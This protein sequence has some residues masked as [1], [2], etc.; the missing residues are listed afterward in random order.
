MST[1]IVQVLL[2]L[3]QNKSIFDYQDSHGSVV[4]DIVK[5]PFRKKELVGVVWD[6][7]KSK[8]RGKFELKNVLQI[9]RNVRINQPIIKLIDFVAHYTMTKPGSLANLMLYDEKFFDRDDDFVSDVQEII[10][11][12]PE[13]NDEQK[14]ALEKIVDVSKNKKHKTIL[15]DGST[16]S[17]KTE[18]Y[19]HAIAKT[20]EEHK[21]GQILILLPEIMLTEQLIARVKERF[22]INPA[23]WHSRVSKKQKTQIWHNILH[24]REK[25]VIGARSAL[26]L[27]YKNLQ[28]IIVDEEHDSSYKQEEGIIYNA[29][30]M[31]VAYGHFRNIPTLLISATPSIET[32]HNVDI[33]KYE[34]V[35]LTSRYQDHSLPYMHV[36]NMKEQRLKSGEWLSKHLRSRIKRC[37]DEGKQVLLFLNRKGYAPISMCISC[38]SKLECQSCSSFLVYHKYKNKYVCHHCGYSMPYTKDCKKCDAEES[39]VNCGPGVER[40]VEEVTKLWPDKRVLAVSRESVEDTHGKEESVIDLIMQEKVDVIVGTQILSKGYHFPKLGLVG[41]VDADIGL[42]GADL[43]SA[44]RT[45]QLLTQVSGRAGREGRGDAIIQ[46]YSPDNPILQALIRGK[47]EQFYSMEIEQ[48]HMVSM[49]PFSRLIALVVSAVSEKKLE[50]FVNMMIRKAPVSHNIKVLGPVEAPIYK[51]RRRYRYRFLIKSSASVNTQQYVEQWLAL[52]KIPASIRIKIDV[53]PYS[54]L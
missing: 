49:P 7:G 20:L 26:F 24:G 5:V 22:A 11:K 10:P 45:Y 53:D 46:T 44:E 32:K 51:I 25:I 4:G 27:P 21:D 52:L 43:K 2:P 13:L 48:R 35:Y 30:D 23:V 6:V 14:E 41:V 12:L 38:G 34:A 40:I 47:K 18:V 8:D 17:G 19:N 36:V 1:Q 33:G 15:L 50:N 42:I 54:F 39:M 31:A 37:F 28:L 29:R 9:Y 16:G 3:S